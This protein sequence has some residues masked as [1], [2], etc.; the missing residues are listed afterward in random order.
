MPAEL[1]YEGNFV[2][3]AD[4]HGGQH[5]ALQVVELIA[6]AGFT[7]VRLGAEQSWGRAA[8]WR[9]GIA[10]WRCAAGLRN[11]RRLIPALGHHMDR[12]RTALPGRPPVVVW[13]S[14]SNWIFAE[15]AKAAGVAVIAAPQN[16]EALVRPGPDPLT[17]EVI[18]ASLEHE[19]RALAVSDAV[20]TISREEQWLL[21]CAAWRR[22]FCRI[23]RRRR[24]RRSCVA[25]AASDKW[26]SDS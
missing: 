1:L 2:P 3:S 25:F 7:P 9:Q 20:F 16:L 23:T 17:G 14:T 22:S 8:R 26:A 19:L 6:R 10:A 13:E 24:W 15:A 11:L 5:R 21:C 4:G 12:V 18:P